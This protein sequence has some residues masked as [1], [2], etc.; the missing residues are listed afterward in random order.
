VENG[1]T[2]LMAVSSGSYESP[3]AS[4]LVD[5][6]ALFLAEFMLTDFSGNLKNLI[7]RVTE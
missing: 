5:Q 1:R 6:L 4:V 7:G 2:L 3:H